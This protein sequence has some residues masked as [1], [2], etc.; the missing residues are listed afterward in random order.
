MLKEE[1]IELVRDA[2]QRQRPEK[3]EGAAEAMLLPLR[4]NNRRGI[5]IAVRQ[6]RLF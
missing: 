5:S 2:E 4:E 6:E 1:Q 3:A